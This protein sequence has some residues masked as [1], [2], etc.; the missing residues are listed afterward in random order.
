MSTQEIDG[1]KFFASSNSFM[2][3]LPQLVEGNMQDTPDGVRNSVIEPRVGM[4]FDSL[5]QVIEFYK[6]YAYSKRI[7][8]N[9]KEFKEK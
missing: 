4:E 8:N 9:D 6:N 7:C 2:E 3:D 5:K 1:V